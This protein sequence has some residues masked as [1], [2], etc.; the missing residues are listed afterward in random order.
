VIL[1]IDA[2]LSPALASWIRDH[3]AVEAVSVRD[4]GLR[5][6]K[7]SEIFRAGRA[8]EAVVMT[9]DSDFSILLE[10]FGPPPKIIWL[11]CGNTSNAFLER[12]LTR[13]LGQ[14]IALLESGESL[15]EITDLP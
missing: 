2:Q 1:W 12:L 13:T 6:A 9:K 11:R 10:R 5:N 14:A 4:L 15:V 3:F 8:A 7:D